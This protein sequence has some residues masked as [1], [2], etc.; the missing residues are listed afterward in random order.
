MGHF[1]NR[2]SCDVMLAGNKKI[3]TRIG[4]SFGDHVLIIA[5]NSATDV[6]V[7]LRIT[8]GETADSNQKVTTR[9]MS[10]N[11]Q[12]LCLKIVVRG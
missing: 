6:P 5:S 8:N 2:T 4:S 1:V 7:E 10:I 9:L 12:L 11:F 3:I